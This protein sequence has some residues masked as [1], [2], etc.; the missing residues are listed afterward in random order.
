VEA[1]PSSSRC[2]CQCCSVYAFAIQGGQFAP[3][4]VLG[5]LCQQAASSGCSHQSHQWCCCLAGGRTSSTGRNQ[6]CSSSLS[7]RSYGLGSAVHTSCAGRRGP[8]PCTSPRLASGH[9]H[10]TAAMVGGAESAGRNGGESP[11][12]A[13]EGFRSTCRVAGGYS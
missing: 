3:W 7:R 8:R 12:T 4:G 11:A 1:R 5:V 6:A 10:Q 9:S 13:G 2:T